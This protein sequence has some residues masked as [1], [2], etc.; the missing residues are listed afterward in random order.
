MWCLKKPERGTWPRV[1]ESACVPNASSSTKQELRERRA[2][3]GKP[4]DSSRKSQLRSAQEGPAFP[5]LR[6]GRHGRWKGEG[7]TSSSETFPLVLEGA[8]SSLTGL[9][10][11]I[12]LGNKNLDLGIMSP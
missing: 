12:I 5:G 6:F 9:S 2:T 4:M 3:V 8:P 10:L 1:L 11:N 7:E